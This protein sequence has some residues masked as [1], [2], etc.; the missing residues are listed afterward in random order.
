M[1]NA[2]CEMRQR[3]LRPRSCVLRRGLRPRL[4][5]SRSPLGL[6]PSQCRRGLRPRLPASPPRRG[7]R[8][9]STRT[10]AVG[11]PVFIHACSPGQSSLRSS[12]GR[13]GFA[14]RGG[15]PPH[16]LTPAADAAPPRRHVGRLRRG[17]SLA[18]LGRPRLRLSP[19]ALPALLYA[20]LRSAT[21][22]LA[23]LPPLPRSTSCRGKGGRR[24]CVTPLPPQTQTQMQLKHPLPRAIPTLTRRR[25][26]RRPA[27]RS[28][29]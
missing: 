27:A 6:R 28:N 23:P 4:P 24:R 22:R 9:R 5:A 3:G 8:P 16:P 15:G 19:P 18:A 14:P 25:L 12:A 21:A 1:R 20:P 29:K 11:A 2:K 10:S 13:R 17:G 7:L 26:R